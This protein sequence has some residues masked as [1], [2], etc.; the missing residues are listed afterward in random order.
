M[1][2][3]VTLLVVVA[4]VGRLSAVEPEADRDA[5]LAE[6]AAKAPADL[7]GREAAVYEAY[8]AVLAGQSGDG[9]SDEVLAIFRRNALKH[10]EKSVRERAAA[11]SAQ[12][13]AQSSVKFI[14]I[15]VQ[16]GSLMSEPWLKGV[17]RVFEYAV[18]QDVAIVVF[19]LDTPGGR[20][21][22]AEG[23]TELMRAHAD[24]FE[25]VGRIRKAISAGI[26][27]A[28]ACDRL[29]VEPGGTMGGAVAFYETKTGA[30]EV[31][32]K[33]NSI[34]SANVAAAAEAK[35]YAPQVVRAMMLMDAEV[36]AWREG[37]AVTIRDHL[38]AEVDAASV[39]VRDDATQV[40]TLT[41]AQLV[42]LGMAT[43]VQPGEALP[44]ADAAT[45]KLESP[46]IPASRIIEQVTGLHDARKFREDAQKFAAERKQQEEIKDLVERVPRLVKAIN[47]GIREAKASD[48][49]NGKYYIDEQGYLT[50]DSIK[51]WRAYTD[52]AMAAWRRVGE[53]ATALIAAE[54]RARE[55]GLE[56]PKHEANPEDVAI[57]AAREIERLREN[58]DR[59]KI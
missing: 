58:R 3:I 29:Y 30:I 1:R 8:A 33:L 18:Q 48:P 36:Y 59:R 50:W 32:A 44:L 54:K 42:D 46:P 25:Y 21:D 40:L 10:A 4:T 24:R 9:M 2:T 16:E 22:V 49:G 20:V 45:V 56:T 7:R 34:F 28:Y 52:D 6:Y 47:A 23:L 55:L 26:W 38:P 39:I 43:K 35:G 41:A 37:E 15:A 53:G 27:I 19:E 51:R 12:A 5:W 17:A 14:T 31:D 13:D 57:R 11:E